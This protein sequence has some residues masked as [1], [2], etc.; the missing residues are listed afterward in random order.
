MLTAIEAVEDLTADIETV[1]LLELPKGEAYI[2][3]IKDTEKVSTKT[4]RKRRR[5]KPKPTSE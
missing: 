4:T 1:E 2:E 3:P 5:R